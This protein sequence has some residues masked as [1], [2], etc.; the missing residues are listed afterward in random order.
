MDLNYEPPFNE[1]TKKLREKVQLEDNSSLN[2]LLSKLY[3]IY[4]DE[5]R[6]LIYD[7]KN[8]EELNKLLSIIINGKN[9]RDEKFLDTTLQDGDDVTFLYIYFG[10]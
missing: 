6:K 3:N 4:G 5:F 10:G 7:K 1:L 8:E 2:D 9:Y